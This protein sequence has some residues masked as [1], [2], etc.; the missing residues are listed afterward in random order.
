MSKAA[1]RA[2]V[3]SWQAETVKFPLNLHLVKPGPMPTAVRGRFY[4]GENRAVLPHPRDEAE[5]VLTCLLD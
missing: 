2:L 1:Q 5:R 4:P 3:Q